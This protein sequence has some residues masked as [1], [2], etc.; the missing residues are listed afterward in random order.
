MVL[1]PSHIHISK[2]LRKRIKR[3][4]FTVSADRCFDEVIKACSAAPRDG[5]LG[6]WIDSN[7]IEAYITLHQQG[8]AHSVE[9]WQG[10]DLVGGLYGVSIGKVFFGESMFSRRTDASKVAM[11][12]LAQTLQQW[13][14][15]LID[16]QVANPH[17]FTMGAQ[18]IERERFQAILRENVDQPANHHWHDLDVIWKQSP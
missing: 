8:H 18:E 13:G 2:S 7:M 10:D 14:Y 9:V 5:Q 1:Y 4:E 12:A 17:L 3:D 15:A 6:T 16:C 11:V